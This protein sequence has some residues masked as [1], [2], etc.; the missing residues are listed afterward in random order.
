V[1]I[2]RIGVGVF[3]RTGAPMPDISSAAALRTAVLGAEHI[4]YTQGS[5]GQYIDA[6][7]DTLGVTGQ[8]T[9]R[10]VRVADAETALARVA[11]G[12]SR[13]F[14]FGAITAIKAFEGNGTTYVAPL[15]DSLQN[16]TG[17]DGAVMNGARAP[18]TAAD[19]L[20]FL[21]TPVARRTL[22][23]AGVE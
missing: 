20:E 13:D 23:A 5:S 16:F 7:L 21:T 15:P 6:M 11:A 3:V 10:L 14:G 9:S 22:V 8:L 17:Y 18:Q 19:F 2:G 4:V 1:S 12:T